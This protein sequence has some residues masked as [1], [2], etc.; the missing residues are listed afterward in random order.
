MAPQ[1]KITKVYVMRGKR[2]IAP[3]HGVGEV[4][5]GL[6]EREYKAGKGIY[7]VG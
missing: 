3:D 2:C 1:P 6:L 7:K 4:H 5:A